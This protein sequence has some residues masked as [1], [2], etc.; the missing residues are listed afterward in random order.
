MLPRAVYRYLVVSRLLGPSNVLGFPVCGE[1]LC[2]HCFAL[3]TPA[4]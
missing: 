2:G 1:A 4:S 3:P